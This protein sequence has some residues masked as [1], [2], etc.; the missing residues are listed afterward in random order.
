MA[1]K[2]TE[3]KDEQDFVQL[4]EPVWWNADKTKL[5]AKDDPDAA[6][7]YGGIAT[8]VPREQAE[9]DGLVKA[10]GKPATKQTKPAENKSA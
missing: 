1:F 3:Q 7:A 10:K 5:V 9:A 4:D 2:I 6:H 8:R